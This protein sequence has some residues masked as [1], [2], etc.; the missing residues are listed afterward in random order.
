MNVLSIL[1]PRSDLYL[2]CIREIEKLNYI[3]S[4]TP[5]L[6]MRFSGSV[7]KV[8]VMVGDECLSDTYN[9]SK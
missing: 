7:L 6:L 5:L 4:I 3:N 9:W 8:K 1:S 2:F